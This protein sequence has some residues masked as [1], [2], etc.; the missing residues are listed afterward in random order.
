MSGHPVAKL[1]PQAGR[2]NGLPRP[3]GVVRGGTGLP[4]PRVLVPFEPDN[5]GIRHRYAVGAV[6]HGVV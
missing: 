4:A 5:V 2:P 3:T 1:R 6:L